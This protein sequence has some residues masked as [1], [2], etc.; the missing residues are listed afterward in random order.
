[1]RRQQDRFFHASFVGLARSG[2]TVFIT[3]LV[4]ALLKGAKLPLFE[5]YASQRI[6]R[7]YFEPQP[8]DELPRFAYENHIAALTGENRR[9][10]DST[11]RLSQLRLT[12]DYTSHHFFARQ[13]GSGRIHVD[14]IDYPGEWLL[15]L[16]LMTMNYAEWSHV[17]AIEHI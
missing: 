17:A 12:L 15:D 6:E 3:A 7:A 4:N 2:K 8:D 1:M 10:P 13:F 11:K 9:W 16:P 5:A 14:I